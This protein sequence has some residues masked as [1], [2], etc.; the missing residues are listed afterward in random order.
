[1]KHTFD[2]HKSFTLDLKV[3]VKVLP[4]QATK[5]LR[6]G[7]G[8]A[9]PNLRHRHWR[10]ER[11]QHDAPAALLS[12][13]D[14]IQIL[15]DEQR[16]LSNFERRTKCD[17]SFEWLTKSDFKIW[18]MNEECFQIL[19][20]KQR[21]L[22]NFEWWTKSDFKFLVMNKECFQILSDEQRV[23]SNF[24]WWTKSVSSFEFRVLYFQTEPLAHLSLVSNLSL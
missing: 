7:R 9:V 17:T 16:V 13:K 3:K 10:R 5:A 1:M 15:S 12:G 22:S 2:I 18:V 19:S 11:V 23:L 6:A 24:E 14:P 20:D 21:A 4:V 8:I